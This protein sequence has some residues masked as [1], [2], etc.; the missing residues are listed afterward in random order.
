M[1]PQRDGHPLTGLAGA[2]RVGDIAAVPSGGG[3]GGVDLGWDEAPQAPKPAS[4]ARKPQARKPASPR[5]CK[6]PSP[7]A[8]RPRAGPQAKPASSNDSVS[9]EL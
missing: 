3:W 1:S 4:Q 5:A 8:A 6:P 9:C 2:A 7:Q